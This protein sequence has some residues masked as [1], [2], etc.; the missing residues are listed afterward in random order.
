LLKY[1][2][3]VID[4]FDIRKHAKTNQAVTVTDTRRKKQE[5]IFGQER[6]LRE[7]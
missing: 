4:K 7:F 3:Y 2:N 6:T 5:A 1:T